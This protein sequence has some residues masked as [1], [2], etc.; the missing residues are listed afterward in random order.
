MDRH[1]RPN[2]VF[3]VILRLPKCLEQSIPNSLMP[4]MRR[5]EC[6]LKQSILSRIARISTRQRDVL[7]TTIILH[8]RA[9]ERQTRHPTTSQP[10]LQDSAD[11]VVGLAGGVARPGGGRVGGGLAVELVEGVPV[12]VVEPGGVIVDA[13]EDAAGVGLVDAGFAEAMAVEE[14]GDAMER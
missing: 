8:H 11:V 6:P 9:S 3:A 2:S 1:I 14:W 13:G 12:E 10:T 5:M 4:S 7:D